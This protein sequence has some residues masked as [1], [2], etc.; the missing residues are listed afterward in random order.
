MILPQ[1]M[2]R[3]AKHGD[4]AV[5]YEMQ[6]LDAIAWMESKGV[7]FGVGTTVLDLGC[8][9]GVFGGA[10][11]AKGCSVTF[12][13]ESNYLLPQFRDQPFRSVNLD[14]DTISGLGQFDLVVCS[15][16]LEHLAKPRRLIDAAPD[17]LT[18]TGCFYLSWT[19]WL[20]PW[21]GH[22]FSPW[23]YFGATLGPRVHD[24]FA[25]KP[26]FHKPYLNLFPTYIGGMLQYIRSQGKLAVASIAPRYYTEF[27]WLMSVP[28][29]REFL[30]WNCSLL[31]RKSNKP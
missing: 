22:E 19:N 26:R 11:L 14:R 23:H 31:L 21:G 2:A 24:L 10:L 18:P 16:V 25:K 30:A 1:L 8:G 15:N 5:F 3:F 6:A 13:D 9:H 17:L 12:A 27:G 7:R 4:D 20:S 29:A 28:V